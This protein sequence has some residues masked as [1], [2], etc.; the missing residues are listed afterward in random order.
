MRVGWR[1]APALRPLAMKQLTQAIC[2]LSGCPSRREQTYGGFDGQDFI[3]GDQLPLLFAV[4]LFV[5]VHWPTN[6]HAAGV[7]AIVDTGFCGRSFSSRN[8]T[9]ARPFGLPR[10]S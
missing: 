1:L 10:H 5:G 8:V 3:P 2:D 6:V 4:H 9:P 7:D